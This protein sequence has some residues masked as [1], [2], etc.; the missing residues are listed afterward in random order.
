MK[1]DLEVKTWREHRLNAELSAAWQE[2]AAAL[3]RGEVLEVDPETGKWVL[4]ALSAAP[5]N[6]AAA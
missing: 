3:N 5:V 1:I 4:D 2:F 6:E